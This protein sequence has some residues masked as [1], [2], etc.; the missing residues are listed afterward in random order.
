M[1]PAPLVRLALASALQRLPLA[2]RW[3]IAEALL[4]QEQDAG[5]PNLPL[6]IWYGIEPLVA[7]DKVRA[8]QLT[9]RCKIPL[10]RQYIAR[11]ALAK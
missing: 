8:I 9:T 5:D 7:A 4:S 10:V 11:R 1:T 6:M 3:P 2:Q